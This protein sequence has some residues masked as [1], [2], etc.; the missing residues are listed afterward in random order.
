MTSVLGHSAPSVATRPRSPEAWA[1]PALT[2]RSGPQPLSR[3]MADMVAVAG[4]TTA[5]VWAS[6]RV[7]ISVGPLAW[8]LVFNLVAVLALRRR[9]LHGFRLRPSLWDELG[10]TLACTVIAAAAAITLRSLLAPDLHVA[11]QMLPT[12]ALL[13]ATLFALRTGSALGERRAW[14]RGGAVPTLIIGAGEVGRGVARRLLD[15][16]ELGLR[17]VGFLD[18]EPMMPDG[19]DY[20]PPV[21]GASWD[22]EDQVTRH[23]VKKVVFAFST[24]PHHV[25]LDLMR[26]SHELELDVLVVPRLFEKTSGGIEL[27]HIG[28]M[29]LLHHRP[30]RLRSWQFGMKYALDR[31]IAGLTLAIMAPAMVAI[32]LAVRLSSPGPVFFRQQRVGLDGEPFDMLKFRT[33]SG[34]PETNGEADAGWVRSVTN[35]AAECSSPVIDRRTPVGRFL[36]KYSLDELPQLINV[37]RGEM[38][39]V[40]PRPERVSVAQAFEQVVAGYAER[41]RVKSGMTGWAQ[42][43]GLRGDTS[44][45]DRVEWDNHYIENWTPWFDLKILLMTVA[46]VIN[47]RRSA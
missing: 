8:I 29:P 27:S 16:P 35:G 14:R 38:S 18:K 1:R 28:G 31:V 30:V 47:G 23:G 11:R 34:A 13:T 6:G 4:A 9:G 37:F 32:A 20:G 45:A 39:L 26:R 12:W 24:A 25:Q 46:V 33:M 42:V 15:R 3:G 21:L 17:P 19:A 22:F 43:Q 44:L 40:G 10:A 5:V 36:R 2:P 41:H 7:N